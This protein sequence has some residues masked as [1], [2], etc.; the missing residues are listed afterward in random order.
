MKSVILQ[1]VT[2]DNHLLAIR[3]VLELDSPER[4]ILSVA[5]MNKLGITLLREALK[6]VANTT[7]ILAG[8]RNGVTSIQALE[9]ANELHC[10]VFAVD[11]GPQLRI[12]HPKIYMSRNAN[13]A[14]LAI[15]S[16]NL[17][18]AG[19]RDNIEASI[20]MD[21][22][23]DKSDDRELI[24][25]LEN[26]I[27]GMIRDYPNNVLPISS[28]SK[29]E[30]LLATG[31]V[32]DESEARNSNDA[33]SRNRHKLDNV[34]LMKLE[35]NRTSASVTEG[36]R[37]GDI[38]IPKQVEFIIPVIDALREIGGSGT[39][40]AIHNRVAQIMQ[41]SPEQLSQW[42]VNK[43]RGKV[44]TQIDFAKA[45]LNEWGYVENTADSGGGYRLTEKGH[46]EEIADPQSLL[47]KPDKSDKPE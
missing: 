19:L 3:R 39:T 40:D 32:I 8:I 7:T 13:E 14:R 36:L 44:D 6:P 23:L 4:V 28:A 18:G 41:L 1:G 22:K 15:G 9:A 25:R 35:T 29:I 17:T 46:I 24:K 37:D 11:T 20:V 5:F 16:A 27:D 33:D 26:Q 31:Q 2:P 42:H 43:N 47:R 10:T 34:P 12:F 45:R 38:H 21:L 30:N